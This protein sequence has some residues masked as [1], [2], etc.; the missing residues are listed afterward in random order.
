MA[1]IQDS[2][3]LFP[4]FLG[5]AIQFYWDSVFGRTPRD[6]REWTQPPD[7][8]YA[9]YYSNIVSFPIKS[10]EQCIKSMQLFMGAV[11]L[12]FAPLAPLV[13]VAAA[14]VFWMS[15][16]VYKYQLMFVFVSK[17]ESGGVSP[18]MIFIHSLIG[19][20]H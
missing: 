2:V 12:V 13:V 5:V 7:F 20:L 19:T 17:V 4:F 6:I 1:L 15:S 3:R 10:I 16:W 18:L 9:I 8:Q 11:G 14:I